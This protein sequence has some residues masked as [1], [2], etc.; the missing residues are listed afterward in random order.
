MKYNY[1]DL[2]H[3]IG[4]FSLGAYWAGMKFENHFCSDIEPYTQE[5]YK[6]RFPD[7]IQLGDITEINCQELINKYGKNWIITGGFP[8]QPHSLAGNRK[9]SEDERDLSD[10]CITAIRILQ[11]RFAIFE[12]VPG[13]LTSEGGLFFNGFLKKL[14]AIGYGYEWQDIRA[15]DLGYAH[16]RER[17]WIVAYPNNTGLSEFKSSREKQQGRSRFNRI[18]MRKEWREFD[19]SKAFIRRGVPGIPRR[20]DRIKGLG[21]SIVPHI[22]ELLFRQIKPFL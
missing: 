3:G 14:A 20:M 15:S 18:S 12:N 21:N 10:E 16:R 8:C 1:I 19:T 22:A 9:G 11:P 13:L 2:F 7:S 6:L 4:G 17:I 5:L